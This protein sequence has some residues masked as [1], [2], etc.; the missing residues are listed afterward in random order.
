MKLK[1]K[2]PKVV[3]AMSGGVDSS[4]VAAI[5]KKQGY[6]VVG[7][8]M[9]FW[10]PSGETYG[11]N[12]CCSLE[13]WHEAME[14]ARILDIPIHKVN[15]GKEFK[16]KIVDEFLNDYKKGQTPNPCVACNKFIKFDLLLKYAKTVF[17]A[18]YLATGHYISIKNYELRIKNK[19]QKVFS[20]NRP[21]DK[22]KD[23]TYFLYNLKQVQLKHLL[24][25][26]GEYNKTEIRSL[27][28]KLKLPI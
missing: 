4:V 25:P 27:A 23:Q 1:I 20:L 10:F 5:L 17:G 11:E 9:Q 26:L 19:K 6:E 28:K 14:V 16:K 22:Q 24:F 18:E 15:F 12:R 21:K 2:K 3:V 7:V 13:S 8:F